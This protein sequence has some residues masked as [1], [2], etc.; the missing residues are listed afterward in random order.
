MIKINNLSFAYKRKLD[1]FSGLNL[2]MTGGNIYG[3]LG[4]NGVGKTTL[5]KIIAGL[6]FSKN[7]DCNVLGMN[8]VKRAPGLLSEIFF[9]PEEFD[10]PRLTVGEFEFLYS[11]FYP[12]FKKAEF[13][14]WLKE[15][16]I[17]ENEK[18]SSLSHGQKKKFLIVFGL[19]TDSRILILDEPTNGLDI[20]SKSQ[21]RKMIASSVNE[22]RI[23]LIS[24]HQVRDMQQLIDPVIILSDGKIIFQ[25]SVADI[26]DKL[27][28]RLVKEEPDPQSA[29]FCEKVLGGFSVLSES[30]GNGNGEGDIDLE[31]LFNA[32]VTDNVKINAVFGGDKK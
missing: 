25:E 23:I 3:L 16:S 9:L 5:L 11:P 26:N 8:P 2:S 1:L 22:D 13:A 6:L 12:R 14:G 17:P 24:T 29:L 27:R 18:L 30:N 4:K 32:V 20:P 31:L 19:A 28:V 10:V 7:G 21:F 15:F